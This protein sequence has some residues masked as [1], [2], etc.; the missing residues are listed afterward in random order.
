MQH[1]IRR[2]GPADAS[3]LDRIAPEVFDKPVRADRLAAH[4]AAPGH[5]LIVA[6]ADGEVVGQCAAVVHRHPSR[7]A[8]LFVD[9]VVTARGHR[10][11]GIGRAMFSAMLEWGRELGCGEVWVGTGPGNQ[12]ARALYASFGLHQQPV[13]FYEG[14]L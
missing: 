8:E 12:D 1:D 13:M 4:L 10:R 7:Q 3:L 5:H 6:L 2:V 11:R 9:E 14:D